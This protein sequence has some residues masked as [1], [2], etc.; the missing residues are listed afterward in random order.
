MTLRKQLLLGSAAAATIVAIAGSVAIDMVRGRERRIQLERASAAA[1]TDHQKDACDSSPNWY[2]AGP[3][4]G[5]PSKE[6]LAQPDADVYTKRPDTKPRPFEYFAFDEEFKGVSTAAPRFPDALRVALK[7][8]N[9]VASESWRGPDGTGVET[10]RWTAWPKSDCAI[11]LFRSAPPPHEN[12]ERAGIF[13]GLFAAVFAVTLAVGSPTE[14]RARLVAGAMRNSARSN[15]A[16]VLPVPG[17]DEV[18]SINALF[19]EAAADIRLRAAE[20]RE[21]QDALRRLSEE[22]AT[23]VV[24][25]I[26]DVP[27]RLADILRSVSLTP[28]VREQVQAALRDAQTVSLHAANLV[29]AA[30][31]RDRDAGIQSGSVDLTATVTKVVSAYAMVAA[32][33]GVRLS[34][35]VPDAAV[36]ATGDADLFESMLTNLVDNAVRYNTPGGSASVDLDGD[37]RGRFTLV[38]TSDGDH[39]SAIN[40]E[41]LKYFNGVRRFRGDE[42]RKHRQDEVGLGLAIVHEVTGRAKIALSFRRRDNRGLEVTLEFKGSPGQ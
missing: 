30:R 23:D 25:P 8:G 18:A 32:A 11:L 21:Q 17:S 4:E 37:P 1:V 12:L 40:D 6:E 39:V 22:T 27:Q 38:V 29:T 7:S 14:R 5:R 26:A 9:T 34:A 15:Y 28:A 19:G 36:M 20:I 24:G 42:R 2:L 3:R 10:A 41:M 35:S 13:L 16:A 31:L 33:F